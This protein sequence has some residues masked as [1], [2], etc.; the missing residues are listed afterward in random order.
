[1]V[2]AGAIIGSLVPLLASR[3]GAGF[4]NDYDRRNFVSMGAAAGV[5]A[6]F[7]APIGGAPC[8]HTRE[9]WIMQRRAWRTERE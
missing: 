3:S 4:D 1:M 5:A 6:A 7:N 9:G 2:H 8:T